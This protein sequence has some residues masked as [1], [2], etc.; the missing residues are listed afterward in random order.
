[1]ASC[2]GDAGAA[3]DASEFCWPRCCKELVNLPRSCCKTSKKVSKSPRTLSPWSAELIIAA[4]S[5]FCSV[6]CFVSSQIF[7][8]SAPMRCCCAN[9]YKLT[10]HRQNSEATK[11]AVN[12]RTSEAP[13][14]TTSTRCAE[15]LSA[16]LTAR[17]LAAS[18]Q[19]RVMQ[20]SNHA[21]YCR[22]ASKCFLT[23]NRL[24]YRFLS[25]SPPSTRNAWQ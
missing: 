8:A 16:A 18:A 17:P 14:L 13:E 20:V 10:F 1:M 4:H 22:H 12:D 6:S 2:Q 24:A 21:G 11:S 15:R 5:E 3:P 25:A 23:C 19:H 9:A 7:S